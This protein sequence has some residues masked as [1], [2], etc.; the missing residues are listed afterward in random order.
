MRWIGPVAAACRRAAVPAS[1]LFAA[2][3]MFVAPITSAASPDSVAAFYRGKQVRIVV[4]FGPGAAYDAFA[5]LYARFLPKYIPGSPA[6]IVENKPG[7]ASLIAANYIYSAAPKDGTVLATINRNMPLLQELGDKN[8]RFDAKNF[9]WIGSPSDYSSDGFFLLV[10]TDVAAKKSLLSDRTDNQITI[11]AT[12]RGST[13]SDIAHLLKTTL[14]L[15]VRIIDGYRDDS[16]LVL[17]V[18]NHEVDGAMIGITATNAVRPDW[19]RKDGEMTALLQFARSTRHE[20]FPDAPTAREL[21]K[22]QRTRDLIELAELPFKLG[23]PLIAPPEVPADRV[24]ALQSA[25]MK[26]SADPEYLEQITKLRLMFSPVDGKSLL[27]TVKR[28]QGEP[29]SVKENMKSVWGIN[30]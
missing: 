30:R 23:F 16:A 21:A 29:S 15:N 1:V 9:T 12:A 10:R 27:E 18:D 28:I 11:A 7:A 24:A 22:D 19:M 20:L 4:G 14:N 6:I 2:L 5:R 3:T 17:A 8:A 26:M 25:Y 13:S